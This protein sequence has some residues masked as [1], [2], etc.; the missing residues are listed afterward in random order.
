MRNHTPWWKWLIIAAV[1]LPGAFY[2]LPNLFGD[3]PGIQLRGS[4]GTTLG[5]PQ[6]TTVQRVLD[7]SKISYSSLRLDEQGIRIRFPDTD[8]QLQARDELEIRLPTGYTIALTLMPAAPD[9]LSNV[10][11][12]PMYLG[13]DLRGGVHFLLDVDMESAQRRAE[14]R[15]IADLRSTLREAKIRYR[16]V[17]R[18][19][20]GDLFI[21]LRDAANNKDARVVIEKELPGLLLRDGQDIEG[22]DIKLFLAQSEIDALSEFALEQN[23]TALRNRIDEL[24]VAE[25]VVQR[26]GDR[27]IVVQLPGVQDTARAKRILGRTATLEMMM[28]DEEHS[29]DAALSGKVP[30]G[31]RIY[32]FR[33]GRPILIEKRVIYSGDNIVDAAA[34]IDT[35]SGGPIVSITLDAIGARINQKITGKNIGKRMAVLYIENRSVI[36]TDAQGLPVRDEQGRIVRDKQRLEEVITAPVIRDQLGKRFQ[37][38][39]LDSVTEARDLALMLRAGSLAAPVD[40]IE[41]RTVGPSL[42]QANI[43]QGF[44]SVVVG[45]VLVLVFMAFYYRV[46]GLVANIALALNLVMIVAVLSL[47]QATLT[48]PGVAGIV[49]TVGMAVDANVLIFERIRE[50]I[51]NGSTPQASIFSGYERALW[52]IVDANVTTLIAAIVLFNF[53]TGPIKGFAVTLSI[54][55]LT[56]MFTAIVL[57][58]AL[59]NFF[60]GGKRVKT[61]SI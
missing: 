52:T 16:D 11:A 21:S 14:D 9:W 12:L 6:L 23:M 35:Q 27:R 50:E 3:D 48:L 43:S 18:D 24:G 26:Q 56:S 15:Y 25:P 13:L 4:R 20:A 36:Q 22:T 55:I 53:G 42:G 61:L 38:E 10:G 29:L 47:L 58:R 40:I 51:R 30:P 2:A 60:Y 54:G 17:G 8:S 34:S 28:V 19:V 7:E 33:D 41:E 59:I 44:L 5:T 45:F 37:I 32:R 46:F 31:S 49:L 1:I 57:S 39:G